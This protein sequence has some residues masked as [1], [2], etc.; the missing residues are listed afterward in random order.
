MWS[1]KIKFE[2][3]NGDCVARITFFFESKNRTPHTCVFK[4][5]LAR[6]LENYA[7]FSEAN[8]TQTGWSWV[9]CISS[10]I[11]GAINTGFVLS[12]GVLFPQLMEHFDESREKTGE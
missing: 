8:I 2:F 9:V 11:C 5:T 7:G 10:A 3:A 4:K 1:G 6:Y 12:F